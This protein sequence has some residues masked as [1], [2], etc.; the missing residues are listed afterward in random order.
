MEP[1]R[2][3]RARDHLFSA[4]VDDSGARLCE[5]NVPYGLA[6]LHWVQEQL[7]L[8]QDATCVASPDCTIARNVR[9]W[10]VDAAKRA[11]AA[12]FDIVYVYATHGFLLA[13]FLRPSNQRSD[14]YGGSLE[15]R[16]RLMREMI[17]ETLEAVG[18]TCAVAVRFS[19]ALSG[20]ISR[21]FSLT[22]AAAAQSACRAASMAWSTSCRFWRLAV[23][24]LETAAGSFSVRGSKLIRS[25]G[26]G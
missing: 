1:K 5:A 20:P 18:D 8:P 12:G 13:D 19:A 7:G 6:K 2:L 14:E 26:V 3:E 11:K 15:N 9:R 4:S 10:Q 16:A 23:M 17:E 22:S 24:A 25:S 21:I